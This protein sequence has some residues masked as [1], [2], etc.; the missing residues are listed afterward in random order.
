[1]PG[2]EV[3]DSSSNVLCF[4]SPVM[5]AGRCMHVFLVGRRDE[6]DVRKGGSLSSVVG[7]AANLSEKVRVI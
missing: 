2:I 5:L 1:M 6:L 3:G 4:A 7:P